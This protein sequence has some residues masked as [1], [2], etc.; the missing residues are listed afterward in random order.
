[1]LLRPEE[2]HR[3]SGEGDVV[4]PAPGRD[5][6]VDE[7]VGAA[8]EL[9]VAYLEL[10]RLTAVGALGPHGA[11]CV[12]RGGDPKRVPGAVRE[13]GPSA[14]LDPVRCLDGGEGVQHPD[15]GRARLEHE[16]VAV[17]QASVGG[18]HLVLLQLER[19]RRLCG[20]ARRACRRRRRRRGGC[21]YAGRSRP[22]GEYP[23]SRS[24]DES[25]STHDSAA[26]RRRLLRPRRVLGY[27]L[28]GPDRHRPRRLRGRLP[29][30]RARLRRPHLR[31]EG[32]DT[33][34]QR[35]AASGPSGSSRCRIRSTILRASV[36]KVPAPGEDHRGAGALD[37]LDHV[38]VAL[39]AARLDERGHAGIER[40]PRPVGER[41]ERVRG[42]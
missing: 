4:P 26:R 21:E 24:V 15:L 2:D 1:M 39:R 31:H 23:L 7:Q 14:G 40:Q 8:N 9:A 13:P 11:V 18:C 3:A 16:R 30:R 6:E 32:N 22:C 28:A 29:Q 33:T 37:R 27:A 41:E 17:V 25:R 20:R 35:R 12:Q 38:E 42:E 36:A 5:D 19:R 34:T 10:E